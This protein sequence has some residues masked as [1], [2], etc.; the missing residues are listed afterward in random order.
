MLHPHIV[1]LI[2]VAEKMFRLPAGAIVAED[3]SHPLV[4]Y[5][6][7]AMLVGRQAGCSIDALSF[8]FERDKRTV[9]SNIATAKHHVERGYLWWGD[10]KIDLYDAWQ[11]ALE[12][13]VNVALDD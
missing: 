1:I 13:A 5:R 7:L 9:I 2:R 11:E 8:V 12:R 10:A 3:R 6:Q 4:D